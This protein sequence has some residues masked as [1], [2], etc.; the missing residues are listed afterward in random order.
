MPRIFARPRVRTPQNGISSSSPPPRPPR[1][2][3]GRMKVRHPV[4]SVCEPALGLQ[5]PC[6]VIR[7]PGPSSDPRARRIRPRATLS[8]LHKS[9]FAAGEGLEPLSAFAVRHL[10]PLVVTVPNGG[11]VLPPAPLSQGTRGCPGAHL[12]TALRRPPVRSIEAASVRASHGATG[13]AATAVVHGEALGF[14]DL[15]LRRGLD[16]RPA[17][18]PG[19]RFLGAIGRGAAQLAP[20]QQQQRPAAG[21]TVLPQARRP[22][23]DRWRHAAAACAPVARQLSGARQG[24]QGVRQGSNGPA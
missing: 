15:L 17:G 12:P 14:A 13:L 18:W 11:H 4:Y 20:Q 9:H 1:R 22:L 7:R 16:G 21:L 5:H 8:A 10:A 19:A 6:S 3:G 2:G 24:S 23:T